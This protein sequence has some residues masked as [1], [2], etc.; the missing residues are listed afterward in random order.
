MSLRALLMRALR[1]NLPHQLS[2]PDWLTEISVDIHAT[3]PEGR[4]RADVPEM[5]TT[6]LRTR[7]GLRFHT[8]GRLTDAY[9]LVVGSGG[10][11]M[12]EVAAVDEVDKLFATDPS[13]KT[14]PLDQT[15]DGISGRM[16]SRVTDRGVTLITER[17]MYERTLTDRGTEEI[18][19]TRLTMAELADLLTLVVDRPVVD[20]TR[21]TGLYR[22][23]IELPPANFAI[24]SVFSTVTPASEPS[25]VSPFKAVEALGLKLEPRRLPV[26]TIVVDHIERTP[27]EN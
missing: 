17:S 3:I 10:S 16:R 22:F 26:D 14:A 13:E 19:A 27:T 21:L 11:R 5:L 2:A 23:R 4:S 9:E 12:Q 1:L 18:N 25:G 6:L 15:R 7:F 20:G 8:E 24:R